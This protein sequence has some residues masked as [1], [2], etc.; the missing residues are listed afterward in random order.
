MCKTPL[1]MGVLSMCTNAYTAC[2]FIVFNL[3]QVDPYSGSDQLYY[4]QLKEISFVGSRPRRK[5]LASYLYRRKLVS[6]G[7]YTFMLIRHAS[8][9]CVVECMS[10]YFVYSCNMHVASIYN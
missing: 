4:C 2:T 6:V 5:S 10:M 1:I 9:Y 3:V 8:M 7:V